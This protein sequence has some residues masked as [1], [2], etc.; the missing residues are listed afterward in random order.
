MMKG[1]ATFT[2]SVNS[3]ATARANYTINDSKY[4]E[5]CSK[6]IFVGAIDK[7]RLTG[8]LEI[9]PTND[10]GILITVSYIATYFYPGTVAPAAPAPA[11]K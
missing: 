9:F 5:Y 10:P 2:I 4:K 1:V 8:V 7:P 11:G 3:S 6:S